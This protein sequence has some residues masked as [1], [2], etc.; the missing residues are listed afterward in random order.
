MGGNLASVHST[1]E[2]HGIQRLI[3]R[4]TNAYPHTWLGGSDAIQVPIK[5]FV[6]VGLLIQFSQSFYS[7]VFYSRRVFGSGVMVL[8]STLGSGLQDSQIISRAI[9]TV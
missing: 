5:P 6:T 2:Y 3:W 1:D 8:L 7:I 4:I 9:K